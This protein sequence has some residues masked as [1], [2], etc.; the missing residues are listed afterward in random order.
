MA[1]DVTHPKLICLDGSK[2]LRVAHVLNHPVIQRC[3]LRKIRN[4]KI[5]CR[6]AFAASD[7]REGEPARLENAGNSGSIPPGDHR[8]RTTGTA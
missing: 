3:Q 4:E 8:D 1:L 6:N 5:I 2:A 7:T